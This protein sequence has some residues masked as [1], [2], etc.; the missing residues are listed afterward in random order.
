MARNICWSYVSAY[1]SRNGLL[2]CV[3]FVFTS[4]NNSLLFLVALGIGELRVIDYNLRKILGITNKP[5]RVKNKKL[6]YMACFTIEN[7]AYRLPN[8]NAFLDT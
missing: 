6:P 7:N 2:L 8:V 1:L 5:F 3:Q 4:L